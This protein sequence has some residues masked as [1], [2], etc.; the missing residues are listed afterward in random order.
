MAPG[1]RPSPLREAARRRSR[2]VAARAHPRRVYRRPPSPARQPPERRAAPRC[3]YFGREEAPGRVGRVARALAAV[4]W[5]WCVA[6]LRLVALCAPPP[7]PS[8]VGAPPPPSPARA[9][10][11]APSAP[12]SAACAGAPSNSTEPPPPPPP[13][14]PAPLDHSGQYRSRS[15]SPTRRFPADVTVL[16]HHFSLANLLHSFL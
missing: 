4:L 7:G 3:A 6:L 10:E 15:L 1:T 14:P 12:A 2:R 13:A 11:D 8:G 5:W 16:A 9:A